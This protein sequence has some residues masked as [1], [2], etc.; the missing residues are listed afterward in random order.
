MIEVDVGLLFF[1]KKIFLLEAIGNILYNVFVLDKQCNKKD[2][3]CT[4][5]SVVLP[6]H[7]HTL[8]SY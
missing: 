5:S 6:M 3:L 2:K 7:G 1:L 4:S 8:I